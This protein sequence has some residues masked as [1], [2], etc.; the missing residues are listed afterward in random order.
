MVCDR[1]DTYLIADHTVN[2]AERKTSRDQSSFPVTPYRAK[3]RVLQEEP[4]G[5]FKLREQ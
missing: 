4:N 1:E 2:D 5:V 3:A